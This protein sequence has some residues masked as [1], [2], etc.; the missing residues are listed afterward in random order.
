MKVVVSDQ[1]Y[2]CSR[3]G[4][5]SLREP[6]P[7]YVRGYRTVWEPSHAL[8]RAD[9]Y[10]FEHR[11]VVHDA[12]IDVPEGYD[13]HHVN[14]VKDDNRLENLEVIEKSEHHR[15][16]VR[17]LGYVTNQYGTWPLRSL[18]KGT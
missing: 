8:A 1:C 15:L 7:R 6:K 12:G 16:H 14:G 5:G 18:T 2:R 4:G 3:V 17:A 13:V 11:K 10:V 9:G